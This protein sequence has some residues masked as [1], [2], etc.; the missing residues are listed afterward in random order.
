MFKKINENLKNRFKNTFILFLRKGVYAY[1]F[2]DDWENVHETS[3]PEDEEFY[4]N[5]NMEDATDSDYSHAKK[6]WARF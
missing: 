5:L 1:E 4:S 6:I 2:M 3:L